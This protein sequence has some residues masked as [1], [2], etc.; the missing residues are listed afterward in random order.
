MGFPFLTGFYSKD[1]I[2][3]LAFGSYSLDGTW[4]HWLG[5]LA[6]FL[7]AF[8]SARLIYLTF[9]SPPT[10]RPHDFGLSHESPLAMWFPLLVLGFG[11]IF[12]GFL[13]RDLFM[14]LG[15]TFLGNAVFVIKAGVIMDSEFGVPVFIKW[16][17]VLLSIAGGFAGILLLGSNLIPMAKSNL[18]SSKVY[19]FL[20]NKW[21]F[22]QVYNSFIVKPILWAGHEITYKSLDRGLIEFVGPTGI[23]KVVSAA[24]AYM[25]T[26]LQSGEV[27][28]YALTV[29]VSTVVLALLLGAGSA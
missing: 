27:Y 26:K 8:Y 22:D 16:V 19:A 23:S 15:S 3:E 5:S 28:N 7:T 12:F 29:F 4:G 10:S 21:N 2:L 13:T 9:L 1:A 18:L 20:I 6:A 17:P 25:S 14:G 24:T 11:S